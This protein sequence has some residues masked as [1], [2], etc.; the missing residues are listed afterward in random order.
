MAWGAADLPARPLSWGGK[1]LGGR[2]A[3]VAFVLAAATF[4]YCLPPMQITEVPQELGSLGQL[5]LLNLD[6]NK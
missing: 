6:A 5:R 3:A 4:F 2:D 1:H